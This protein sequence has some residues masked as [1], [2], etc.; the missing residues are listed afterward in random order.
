MTS[1]SFRYLDQ[2]TNLSKLRSEIK[3]SN[4]YLFWRL[5]KLPY[6]I[7]EG[8][9]LF[10][11]NAGRIKMGLQFFTSSFSTLFVNARII[12]C[13]RQ[14]GSSPTETEQLTKKTICTAITCKLNLAFVAGM[15]LSP[16]VFPSVGFITSVNISKS[17]T[18]KWNVLDQTLFSLKGWFA[19]EA[20]LQIA[21]FCTQQIVGTS[22][23][24][25]GKVEFIPI[26]KPTKQPGLKSRKRY[27]FLFSAKNFRN[28]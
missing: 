19:K 12:S 15:L 14:S 23:G 18:W 2:G 22:V 6:S 25:S 16:T 9:F 21:S 5:Q 8:T 13:L 28:F 20:F 10:L 11:R 7:V 4:K 26:K 17:S 3:L 1:D 27:K 24:F